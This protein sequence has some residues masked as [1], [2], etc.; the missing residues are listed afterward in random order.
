[1]ARK[2]DWVQ[3][4]RIV[5]LPE[6]RTG[7]LPEDTKKVP[8]EMWVKGF[9]QNES[10]KVGDRVTIL[11]RAGRAEYGFLIEEKPFFSLD[12]GLFV[13]EILE[14]EMQLCTELWGGDWYGN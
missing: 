7:K 5:L 12:Y 10:A 8:L 6:Q 1:M 4:H 3:I 2:N 13:P 9:L 14:M 11:T